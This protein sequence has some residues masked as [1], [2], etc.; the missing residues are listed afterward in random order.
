M[1]YTD[2]V[3]V[4]VIVVAV[5]LLVNR[6][7]SLADAR[8][9]IELQKRLQKSKERLSASQRGQEQEQPAAPEVGD[10]VPQ[11]ISSFGLDPEMLFEDEMPEELKRFLPLAKAF[12]KSSGGIEGI[13]QKFGG[14]KEQDAEHLTAKWGI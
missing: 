3:V 10:W 7:I 8:A 4:L 6:A 2:L 1:E 5:A 11:L 9:R 13:V 12:V 14:M